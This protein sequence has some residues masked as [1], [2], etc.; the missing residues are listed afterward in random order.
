MQKRGDVVC[1]SL[2]LYTFYFFFFSYVRE[3]KETTST[4]LVHRPGNMQDHQLYLRCRNEETQARGHA[5]S[6]AMN[7]LEEG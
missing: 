5:V 3:S 6:T 1:F 7:L 2:S 4:S